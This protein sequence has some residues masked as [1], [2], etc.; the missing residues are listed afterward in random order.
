[1]SMKKFFTA[2]IIV[3]VIA[4]VFLVSPPGQKIIASANDLYQKLNVFSDMVSIIND[5]YVEDVE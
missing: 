4:G 2:S 1:M 5:N 3:L